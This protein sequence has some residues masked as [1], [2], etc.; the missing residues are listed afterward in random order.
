MADDNT[1]TIAPEGAENTGD[2]G[3]KWTDHEK[4]KFLLK[5][6]EQSGVTPKFSDLNMPGRT[7]KSLTHMWHKIKG[8]IAQGNYGTAHVAATPRKRGAAK[9]DAENGDDP[10]TTPKK[11]RATPKKATTPKTPKKAPKSKAKIEKEETSE[12]EIDKKDIKSS[13]GDQKSS[14]EEIKDEA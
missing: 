4:Y 8:E 14:S 10:N 2:N 11:K 13:D 12:E 9:Q 5:I 3:G 6:I 7:A 1:T